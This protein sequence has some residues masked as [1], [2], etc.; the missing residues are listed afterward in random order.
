MNI[1]HFE[2]INLHFI[3][4]QGASEIILKKCTFVI[5]RDGIICR[6]PQTEKEKIIN[7][8]IKPMALNGL[9]T[10]CL[11]YLDYLWKTDTKQPI[12]ANCKVITNEPDWEDDESFEGMTFLAIIGIEDPV[13]KDVS[14][15]CLLTVMTEDRLMLPP[16]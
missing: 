6:L 8:V 1:A 10:I 5:G 2:S 4:I 7:E 16:H 15:D 12:A 14:L 9:R 11:A 13:R 3:F